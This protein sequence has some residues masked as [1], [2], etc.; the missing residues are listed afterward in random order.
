LMP[1]YSE[2]FLINRYMNTLKKIWNT[3]NLS[4]SLGRMMSLI[5]FTSLLNEKG[6]IEVKDFVQQEEMEKQYMSD[7]D[8]YDTGDLTLFI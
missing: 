4:M 5:G 7:S 3:T 6:V 8:D 2:R 1:K